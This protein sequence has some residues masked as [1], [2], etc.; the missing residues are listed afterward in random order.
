[1]IIKSFPELTAAS[2]V[3]SFRTNQRPCWSLRSGAERQQYRASVPWSFV[4]DLV[5]E[6]AQADFDDG[7]RV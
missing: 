6:L 2:L 1:M 4:L 7:A 3:D 5:A